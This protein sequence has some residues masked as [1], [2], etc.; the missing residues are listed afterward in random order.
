MTVDNNIAYSDH[1]REIG[2]TYYDKIQGHLEPQAP[3]VPFVSSV[4]AEVLFKASDFGPQYWKD[5]ME[6]PVLFHLAATMLLA[7]FPEA[8]THVE[9]GPHSA[10]AGPLR[11]TYAEKAASVQYLSCLT[12]GK[13][14]AGSFL[15]AMGRLHCLGLHAR[16]PVSS[17]A[18]VLTQLP[19]YPWNYKESYWAESR[20]MSSWRFRQHAAH[21]LLGSRITETS[22]L[23][24]SWRNVLRVADVPWLRDHCVGSDLVFPAAGYVAMAGEAVSQLREQNGAEAGYTVRQVHFVAAMLLRDDSSTEVIT[25]LRPRMLTAKLD[26]PWYEFSI[27]SHDGSTWTRHC[28][29]L[30]IS[31][32]GA[33]MQATYKAQT[34][35][36]RV[37]P[38]RWYKAMVRSGLNYGPRFMGLRDVTAAVSK[39]T[40]SAKIVDGREA[41][42]SRY[43]LH[44]TTI[45]AIF[46]SWTV[47]RS[48]GVPRC[49]TNPSLPT[50][51]EQ[52][53]VDVVPVS[54]IIDVVTLGDDKQASSHGMVHGKTVFDLRLLKG[55]R[56]GHADTNESGG[57]A[58]QHLQ[59]KPAA[60][61]A[62]A[63]TL[64]RRN[65]RVDTQ[66]ELSERLFVLCAAEA[67]QR[68]IDVKPS[69]PHFARFLSWLDEQVE[70]LEQP[71]YP[72][73]ED[74]AYL[75]SL[76]SEERVAIIADCV[77]KTESAEF[78]P[79]VLAVWR[80]YSQLGE[81]IDGRVDYLD[82]LLQDDLLQQVYDW[83]N[84]RVDLGDFFSLVA[85]SQPQLT[86]LEI[87]AGTGGLTSN[88]LQSLQS[89]YGERLFLRYVFTD[90][91]SGFVKA[92]E[93][94]KNHDG[95]EYRVLDISRDPA[96][97]G[98]G[99][100]Q[101]DL[102]LASNVGRHYS[103]VDTG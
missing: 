69:Q 50:F 33:Q 16:A 45:D 17:T 97:Q 41:S 30:V 52:L 15:E 36:R 91:S 39:N 29:G 84:H 46:Q 80:A 82:L 18:R 64:M 20:V 38:D 93:R 43:T 54:S 4:K 42:E 1:M 74:S 6:S 5:N 58:A 34:F 62:D 48:R 56:L 102:V 94:F 24:P 19:T 60:D 21:D 13:D 47:A 79:L 75:L 3:C 2:A 101:Y 68:L 14:D 86:I 87:G 26:S 27:V 63:A 53:S 96:E 98:F 49:L 61:F 59:W 103:F 78:G 90:I 10:L 40:A 35:T 8:S 12:R 81:I 51:I 99:L 70:R 7:E 83:T 85:N 88:M 89:D 55:A 77:A 22:D 28:H 66:M 31:G 67:K 44:P 73:V 65:E 37:S 76:T 32:C 9:I 23:E 25:T 72:L 57:F 95:V 100:G 92:Q 11:Q 71:G